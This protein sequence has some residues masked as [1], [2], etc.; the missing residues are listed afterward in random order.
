MALVK[1]NRSL[2]L[3]GTACILLSLIAPLIIEARDFGILHLAEQS[4]NTGST[5]NLIFASVRLVT[6]NTIRSLPI[7]TGALLLAEGLGMFEP[8]RFRWLKF[9]SLL[10]IPA[11]YVAIN[12]IYRITYDFGVTA[13]ALIFVILL[14][15][16]MQNMA[17]RVGHKVMV[18]ALL[19]FGVEWL[20]IVPML[21][22]YSIGRGVLSMDIKT[23]AL[24]NNDVEVLNLIGLSLFVI[25][26][27]D[28]FLIARLLNIYTL[29]IQTVEQ[30]LE[31][32][33]LN[34]QLTL[35]TIE[36]RSLR[37][38]QTLV[39]DLKTPLTSIQGLAGV[40]AMSEDLT[41]V[42]KH[43]NYIST[44]VDKM[45][46]MIDELLRDDSQHIMDVKELVEYAVAHVPQLAR[47]GEFSLTIQ[48]NALVNVNK[49]KVSRAIINILE[50]SLAAVEEI[51]GCINVIVEKKYPQVSIII[52]DNGQGF[53]D[54]YSQEIWQVGF[55]TRR[56]S[57]LGLPFVK[58][59]IE[60]NGGSVHIENNA[61][62]GA[63]VVIMLPEVECDVYKN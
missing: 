34:A 48:D 46:N 28:A 35:Q 36:N 57:G 31:F 9:A 13:I 10:L 20:D 41:I 62:G 32:E 1:A 47:I 7:Y 37:E 24:L 63:K 16:K 22:P 52:L 38:M 56:S 43:A 26:V 49:I 4:I 42:K 30:E 54:E 55:S 15:N 58:D 2:L 14:L 45:S 18:Y 3:L 61:E 8:G 33:H 21:T 59:V 25:F 44:M 11:I 6:L 5:G 27:A 12:I 29:E 50:N 60:K 39:H 23:I 53:I 17:R 19:L 40:I 51:H